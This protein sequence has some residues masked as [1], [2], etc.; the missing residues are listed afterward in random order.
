MSIEKIVEAYRGNNPERVYADAVNNKGKVA[1]ICEGLSVTER[2]NMCFAALAR[3]ATRLPVVETDGEEMGQLFGFSSADENELIRDV[4]VATLTKFILSVVSYPDLI[5]LAS[6]CH[7]SKTP[8]KF[9]DERFQPVA[10]Y[11][12][13]AAHLLRDRRGRELNRWIHQIEAESKV[14]NIGA[15]IP[16]V[17][18]LT[19]DDYTPDTID[20]P[21]TL[22]PELREAFNH[23]PQFDPGAA[24]ARKAKP[25]KAQTEIV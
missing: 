3:M 4:S 21:E 2:M 20:T 19:L 18:G 25:A 24:R 11:A 23:E 16:T 17:G 15:D 5:S 6:E 7:T 1:T 12:L 13:E 10:R 14:A 8:R 9:I 22:N